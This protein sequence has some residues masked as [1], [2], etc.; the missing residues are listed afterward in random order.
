MPYTVKEWEVL[1][2]KAWIDHGLPLYE[3]KNAHRYLSPRTARGGLPNLSTADTQA[4]T[5]EIEAFVANNEAL[6]W[7]AMSSHSG[8]NVGAA[9]DIYLRWHFSPDRKEAQR[10]EDENGL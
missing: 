7:R 1:C 6:L 9:V 2:G 5:A 3:A 10:L 4:L 8:C